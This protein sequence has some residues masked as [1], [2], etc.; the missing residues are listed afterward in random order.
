M[1][2]VLN[3]VVLCVDMTTWMT[4]VAVVVVIVVFFTVVVAVVKRSVDLL[5]EDAMH[6]A[7]DG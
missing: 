5:A 2:A 6:V 3:V 4:L 1:H 7:T